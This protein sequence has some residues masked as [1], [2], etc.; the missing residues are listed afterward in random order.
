MPR[1]L[2]SSIDHIQDV[3]GYDW[4]TVVYLRM[5]RAVTVCEGEWPGE[6]RTSRKKATVNVHT[7]VYV[8]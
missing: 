8:H 5:A 6:E 7:L 3:H 4:M 1:E 2:C